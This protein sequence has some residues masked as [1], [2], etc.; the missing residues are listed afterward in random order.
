MCAAVVCVAAIAPL[1]RQ[2]H[3]TCGEPCKLPVAVPE[4]PKAPSSLLLVAPKVPC[5]ARDNIGRWVCSPPRSTTSYSPNVML[6][7]DAI[8]SRIYVTGLPPSAL[9]GRTTSVTVP[10]RGAGGG[11]SSASAG[12][13]A[14]AAGGGSGG[15]PTVSAPSGVLRKI[16]GVEE[17]L[18]FPADH[19]PPERT[20]PD[21]VF[22]S[23]A[24]RKRGRE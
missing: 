22:P 4:E 8:G 7:E 11:G 14:S 3:D 23:R 6:K 10:P 5:Y 18:S 17:R 24:T 16:G 12:A 20:I 2:L 9:L 13:G 15:G 1:S 21:P 19:V